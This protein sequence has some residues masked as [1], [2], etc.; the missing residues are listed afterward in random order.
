[1]GSLRHTWTLNDPEWQSTFQR[2]VWW[3]PLHNIHYTLVRS[4]PVGWHKYFPGPMGMT[5]ECQAL[6]WDSWKLGSY[7]LSPASRLQLVSFTNNYLQQF[8]TNEGISYFRIPCLSVLVPR[9]LHL[10]WVARALIPQVPALQLCTLSPKV[11]S[12]N[13]AQSPGPNFYCSYLFCWG[14]TIW[15]WPLFWIFTLKAIRSFCL[16]HGKQEPKDLSPPTSL[17]VLLIVWLERQTTYLIRPL[18]LPLGCFTF[19]FF[20]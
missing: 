5:V 1:M 8:P 3:V 10:N 14:A 12:S 19:S 17:S 7:P 2:P 20:Y 18:P 11:M 9:V 4:A 16:T 6:F 13:Q 15:L